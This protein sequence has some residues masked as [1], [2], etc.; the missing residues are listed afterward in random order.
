[1]LGR[2]LPSTRFSHP[3]VSLLVLNAYRWY[4]NINR[5]SIAYG[6]RPRL[7]PRLALSGRTFLRKP[8]VFD[9]VD[10]HHPL[11]TYT[12]IL[13]CIMST[14]PFGQAS[15][16]IQRSPTTPVVGRRAT[17]VRISVFPVICKVVFLLSHIVHLSPATLFLQC[18]SGPYTTLSVL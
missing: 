16:L 15:A 18:N 12:G 6:F 2:A 8:K 10:S 13:S 11:A 14:C 1:M 7:R 3:P 5:L 17:V 9:G 4:R